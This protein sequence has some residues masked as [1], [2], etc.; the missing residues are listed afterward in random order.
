MRSA[1]YKKI[2]RELAA[3]ERAEVNKRKAEQ[4]RQKREESEVLEATGRRDAPVCAWLATHGLEQYYSRIRKFGAVRPEELSA[5]SPAD[6]D[7]MGMK[8]LEKSR[9]LKAV[10]E[11]TQVTVEKVAVTVYMATEVDGAVVHDE[12]GG[13]HLRFSVG[14]S[15]LILRQKA[16]AA[17]GMADRVGVRLEY[18]VDGPRWFAIVDAED[19]EDAVASSAAAL[20]MGAAAET[21]EPEA[22]RAERSLTIRVVVPETAAVVRSRTPPQ[23][24]DAAAEPI[25]PGRCDPSFF[26]RA[27]THSHMVTR[28][29]HDVMAA[30]LKLRLRVV[31]LQP[32]VLGRCGAGSL[33]CWLESSRLHRCCAELQRVCRAAGAAAR[34]A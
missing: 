2:R 10:E 9:F 31:R 20:R 6:L 32:G 19:M 24:A 5:L 33:P 3:K 4:L 28:V 30:W 8:K 17:L 22:A 34:G 13:C 23:G 1:R 27:S 21:D 26:P 18:L 12:A 7:D 25:S 16:C 15:H 29:H 14:T 11:M